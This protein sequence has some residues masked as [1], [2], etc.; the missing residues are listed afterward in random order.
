MFARNHLRH[1][2]ATAE[3]DPFEVCVDHAVPVAFVLLDHRLEHSFTSVIHQ[4]VNPSETL[5]GLLNHELDVLVTANVGR[6]SQRV[7]SQVLDSCHHRRDSFGCLFSNDYMGSGPR[8][9]QGDSAANPLARA[10]DDGDSSHGVLVCDAAACNLEELRVFNNQANITLSL[11]PDP[12][13]WVEIG[14]DL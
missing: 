9:A 3:K 1:N 13:R 6:N 11:S 7:H 10:S 8:E 4:Y 14:L 2:I 5:E 12:M